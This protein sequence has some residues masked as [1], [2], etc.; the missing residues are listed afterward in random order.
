V[1]T[2]L[3]KLQTWCSSSRRVFRVPNCAPGTGMGFWVPHSTWGPPGKIPHPRNKETV[4]ARRANTSRQTLEVSLPFEPGHISPACVAQAYEWVMPIRRRPALSK[5][6]APTQAEQPTP[7][8]PVRRR[9]SACV[10][11][12]RRSTPASRLNAKP[13]PRPLAANSR[14]GASVSRS[15]GPCDPRRCSFWMTALVGPPWCGQPWSAC[16]I[17]W[18]RALS[19]GCLSIRRIGEPASTPTKSCWSMNSTGPGSRSCS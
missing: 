13:R 6:L 1:I 12:R 3:T 18:R 11:P 9:D 2:L 15:T 16:V 10:R 14:R 17:S 4:V 5:T 19:T 8:Q 7:Q